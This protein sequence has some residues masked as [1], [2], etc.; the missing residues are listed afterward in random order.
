MKI[1]IPV[2]LF[3]SVPFKGSS[4]L[5]KG[6]WTGTIITYDTA[7]NRLNYYPTIKLKFIL[8]D[9]VYSVY[10]YSDGQDT[11][12]N[13]TTV[14]CKV[15]YELIGKDSIY[16]EEVEVIQPQNIKPLCMQK[17]FLKVLKKKKV[18]ILEGLWE[19]EPNQ[20][21]TFGTIRF[22]RKEN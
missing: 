13:D 22:R 3:F 17:M 2:I 5:L 7:G 21:A 4:Q 15:Y 14:V 6:E 1:L 18:T 12:G 19:S 9:D 10:S 16:L 11:N 20:C 8:N